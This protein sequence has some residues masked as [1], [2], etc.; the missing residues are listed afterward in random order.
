MTA[1]AVLATGI[2]K[3]Y[4]L[5][6]RR[7]YQTL[8]E[9]IMAT[10]QLKRSRTADPGEHWALED[11]SFRIEPGEVLGIIG[12]NG[13]GKSTLLKILSRITE[14]T[15]GRVEIRGRVASLLEVGTGFH[16][17]LS[18]RENVQLNGAILGMRRAEIVRKFD[19]IVAFAEVEKFIDTP[20]KF[21]SSGMYLRLAF[22][23]AAHFESEILVVDEV[24]A[25]GDQAFQQRCLGKMG[26]AATSGRT[27]LLVSHNMAAV[28]RLCER[29]LLLVGGR[30]E[31]DGPVDEVVR[32]YASVGNAVLSASLASRTDRRGSGAMRFERLR[33]YVEGADEHAL[34]SGCDAAI[35]LE[36]RAS[37]ESN[38]L[39]VAISVL[40]Q[41]DRM[42]FALDNT[43]AGSSL[44]VASK[45]TLRCLIPALPL[46][47]GT[48][49][50]NVWAS[51]GG[52]VA[53][54]V[55]H[56]AEFTVSPAD[57]YGTG[58]LPDHPKFG[59]FLVKH[60]WWNG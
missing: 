18:G 58:K 13:A 9:A 33:M 42:L 23:V 24:L 57:F 20:V 43:H 46:S 12:R 38:Q 1:P 17:E 50:L 37:V 28:E 7:P 36:Y 56:A 22:A 30:V 25:V 55:Q 35:E 10:V 4:A 48:Y 3:R 60:R 8:R 5:G 27:V 14:P 45:G 49:R 39:Q 32:R 40:D 34:F 2:S 47:P 44:A 29:A 16:P 41:H 21:Y 31:M 59:P 15:A 53:D 52:T 6:G 19:E 26:E 54:H 11:V 51:V